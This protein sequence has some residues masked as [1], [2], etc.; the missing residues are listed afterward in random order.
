[1]DSELSRPLSMV[2]TQPPTA[3]SAAAG[4]EDCVRGDFG[5]FVCV[6]NVEG[7]IE[8]LDPYAVRVGCAQL[9]GDWQPVEDSVHDGVTGAHRVSL[10]R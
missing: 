10:H 5:S 3:D 9:G 8:G 7:Q 4:D 2:R 1:M 6:E